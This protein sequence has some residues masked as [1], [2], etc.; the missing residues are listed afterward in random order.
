MT[1]QS[2]DHWVLVPGTLC[3]PE[4]FAPVLKHLGVPPERQQVIEVSSPR[5]EDYDAPL[6][7]AIKGGEVV[8][9]FSLGA[10]I[11]AHNLGALEKAKAVVLLALNPFPDAPGRRAGREATRD[12]V[13]AGDA[14]GWIKEH[15]AAMSRD[16]GETVKAQ[17]INMAEDMT[18]NIAA[19]TELALSRPGAADQLKATV[20][21]LVFV[22]GAQDTLTPPDPIRP[23]AESC[24]H[25][26]LYVLDGLGH[27]ALLEAPDR[28]ALAI[29][30]GLN[31]V[32]SKSKQ[33][34]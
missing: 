23:I 17:V 1:L 8:C 5:V 19:Q 12:R 11:L 16:T 25:G 15:W 27:F 34:G 14:S 31:A 20:T 29:A 13:L 32:A 7:S 4:V 9:G 26:R 10:M 2:S 24:G 21:P 30:E 18:G 28:V 6:R 33:E 3:T 22:T